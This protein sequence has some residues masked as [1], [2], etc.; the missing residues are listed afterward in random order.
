MKLGRHI[1]R[2]A[3][4]VPVLGIVAFGCGWPIET[5]H[6]VRFNWDMNSRDELMRMPPLRAREVIP[7]NAID[8]DRYWHYG[9]EDDENGAD[10]AKRIDALW[11]DANEAVQRGDLRKARTQ[12]EAYL[13]LTEG[14]S[15]DSYR[16]PESQQARRNS[17]IDR[18]DAIGGLDRGASVAA[19]TAYIAAREVY[20]LGGDAT[21]VL[22]LSA[23]DPQ[24]RDNEAYLAAAFAYHDGA[25]EQAA[26]EFAAMVARFPRSEKREAALYMTA[27]SNLRLGEWET[28]RR[29]FARQL[30]EFPSGRFASEA[31]GWDAHLLWTMERR[32][33]ALA[34]YYRMLASPD[35]RLVRIPV[36]SLRLTRPKME[37]GEMHEVERFL[38]SDPRAALAYAYYELYNYAPW[39][40]EEQSSQY[41]DAPAVYR[42]TRDDNV[43][44]IVEFATR[45]VDRAPRSAVSAAFTLRLAMAQLELGR[46][47]DAATR[48]RQRS[49]SACLARSARG[50]ST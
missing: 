41:A 22:P 27:L 49:R 2:A 42:G 6:T 46:N 18:L 16:M 4:A 36:T 9:G 17:A 47:A 38:S 5:K 37:D 1:V 29:G 28:A 39:L 13:R 34:A 11:D 12:Y 19:V 10:E 7:R 15:E 50:R 43:A 26:S 32:T 25:Y 8:D 21:S 3:V 20:D 31:R 14:R 35:D 40:A 23:G 24:V 45:M 33:E 44:R 48:A 30:V